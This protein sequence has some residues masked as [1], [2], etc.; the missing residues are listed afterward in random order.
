MDVASTNC[1]NTIVDKVCYTF[2]KPGHQAGNYPNKEN[3]NALLAEE[4]KQIKGKEQKI[5]SYVNQLRLL[6]ILPSVIV[7]DIEEDV[8]GNVS[9]V[10][11]SD[12]INDLSYATTV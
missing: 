5:A 3:V 11:V 2:K 6:N 12:T 1:G 10:N 9:Y 8:T 4:N 7:M